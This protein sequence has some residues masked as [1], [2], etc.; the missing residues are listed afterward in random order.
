MKTGL[1]RCG[2]NVFICMVFDALPDNTSAVYVVVPNEEGHAEK[3]YYLQKNALIS[4]VTV[5]SVDSGDLDFFRRLKLNNRGLTKDELTDLKDNRH[6]K[7]TENVYGSGGFARVKRSR[8]LD[9]EHSIKKSDSLSTLNDGDDDKDQIK[10]WLSVLSSEDVSPEKSQLAKYPAYWSSC[11]ANSQ[12]CITQNYLED[13]KVAALRTIYCNPEPKLSD[14]A[15][16]IL[17]KQDF[18]HLPRPIQALFD[19]TQIKALFSGHRKL[20]TERFLAAVLIEYQCN[21]NLSDADYEQLI[22]Q[23]RQ[24]P[25]LQTYL[26][27]LF[28]N[29]VSSPADFLDSEL[30]QSPFSSKKIKL[31]PMPLE[32]KH[33]WFQSIPSLWKKS[34]S[35][36]PASIYPTTDVDEHDENDRTSPS[37]S[38]KLK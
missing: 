11:L 29:P 1:E 17:N 3:V 28:K 26:I 38:K 36:N 8:S 21:N 33:S 20:E 22:A 12:W 25:V 31:K 34:N 32:R 27:E 14:E 30:D 18:A 5:V 2:I 19:S 15:C 35:T 7:H 16:S 37:D 9:S 10:G 4:D 24:T 13:D 23:L 6:V